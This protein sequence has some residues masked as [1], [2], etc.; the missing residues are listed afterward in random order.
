MPDSDVPDG[1]VPD[2]DVPDGD[3]PDD[4]VPDGDVPDGDDVAADSPSAVG[5]L[6]R[7]SSRASLVLINRAKMNHYSSQVVTISNRQ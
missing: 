1:D 7:K 4:D 3:V 5:L 6:I 2:G